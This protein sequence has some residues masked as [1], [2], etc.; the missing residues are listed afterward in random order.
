MMGVVLVGVFLKA[1]PFAERHNMKFEQLMEG[2]ENAVRRYWGKRGEQVVQDNL[3][4]I[5]RGYND[6]I[7]LPRELID[8][9]S[10]DEDAPAALPVVS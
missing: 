6:V 8:D 9:T 2:V 5:S 1:T 4:C 3:T 7:E 10:L